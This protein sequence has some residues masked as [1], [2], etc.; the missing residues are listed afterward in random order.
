MIGEMDHPESI[1]SF[2]VPEAA[3][4]LGRSEA[5]IRRWLADD[6]IPAPILEDVQRH[7]KVYSVGE[8]RII[9]QFLRE[10]EREFTYLTT[11]HNNLVETLH[12][13]VHGYR[14]QHI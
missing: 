10:H 13:A 14:A 8:M 7:Y 12:Q 5:T 1:E 3:E 4:A 6:K 9:G 11:D 2:T